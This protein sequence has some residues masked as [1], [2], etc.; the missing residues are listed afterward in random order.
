MA[1]KVRLP[2]FGAATD[3][4]MAYN[5][6]AS[7]SQ[8]Q[9]AAKELFNAALAD[10]PDVAAAAAL[11]AASAVVDELAEQ[12]IVVRY[13]GR[14]L[15]VAPGGPTYWGPLPRSSG[16]VWGVIMSGASGDYV[17]LG[18]KLNGDIG[19]R[20][21][22]GGG[23]SIASNV[24]WRVLDCIQEWWIGPV[25]QRHQGWY[26]T[27][28][29]GNAGQVLA[30]DV[31]DRTPPVAVQV[32]TT[33]LV[34]DHNVPARFVLPGR[35]SLMEWTEHGSTTN[36]FFSVAPGSGRAETHRGRAVQTIE[37][38]T[39]TSYGQIFHRPWLQT[40]NTDT[41][42][43]LLRNDSAWGIQEVVVNWSTGIIT[44]SGAFKR[45]VSFSAQPYVRSVEGGTNT[46]GNPCVRLAIGYNPGAVRHEVYAGELDLVTGIFRDIA[47]PALTHNINSGTYLS[48]SALTPILPDTAPAIRRLL[49][50][51]PR[52]GGEDWGIL[53]VE[54]TTPEVSPAG[55]IRESIYSPS[56]GQVT[57]SR[58]FGAVGAHMARYPAGASYAD[59]G[60]VWHSNEAGG[61]WT[62][63]HEGTPVH[64]STNGLLRPM[65]TP[66][67]GPV[68]VLV[69][70]V[71][72]Y[73]SYLD[74]RA[75]LLAISKEAA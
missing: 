62:L 20:L 34:D 32:G 59:D 29:L 69:S 70:E 66:P 37:I 67:G 58:T 23:G 74:W 35:G 53:T 63:S 57:G 64:R 72:Y 10:S 19:G 36:L 54:Y 7:G 6:K 18:V 1:E 71:F 50:I 47:N 68:D 22:G 45:F 5:L 24:I 55:V 46:A 56:T 30:V 13:D 65:P 33:A 75:D 38:G 15:P 31:D 41:F 11:A 51:R 60:T 27:V 26:S 8:S 52:A 25:V 61:T 73:P 2:D 49:G 43:V 3:Q 9:N 12:D 48:D 44:A 14:A 28:G 42:W 40:T 4:T 16:Y 39:G 17:A 21:A